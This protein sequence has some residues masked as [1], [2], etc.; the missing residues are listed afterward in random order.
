MSTEKRIFGGNPPENVLKKL[1]LLQQSGSVAPL[2]SINPN[3]DDYLGGRTP[4][5]R[6]WT[7]TQ[8]T[9]SG[10][11]E[12]K[13][14]FHSV[15]EN[16]GFNYEE[17]L[18]PIVS[19]QYQR[20]NISNQ[21]LK[22]TAGITS[23]SSKSEG[24]LGALRST[25]VE[26]EVH[27]KRDFEEIFLPFFLRPGAMVC[28]DFGWSSDR[29]KLYDP[30]QMIS[31]GTIT[32][33]KFDTDIKEKVAD[34]L[35]ELEV[36]VGVVRKY[37]ASI[38]ELGSFKCSLE[39]VSRN[40]SLLDA[41]ITEDNSLKFIFAN[42]LEDIIVK[43]ITGDEDILKKYQSLEQNP[44][45]PT[46]Y[47]EA[48]KAFFDTLEQPSDL[49]VLR[50]VDIKR[51]IFYQDILD[52]GRFRRGGAISSPSFGAEENEAG[53]E[54]E[55]LYICYGLFEDLFLNNFVK[56]VITKKDGETVSS[57]EEKLT[58]GFD[59][60]KSRIKWSSDLYKIQ[61]QPLSKGE[62]L[63]SFLLPNSDGWEESY[64][65]NPN[66][67]FEEDVANGVIPLRELFIKTSLL[68]EGFRKKQNVNDALE[69]IWETIN[70]ESQNIWKIKMSSSKKE[71][72][73]ID[74]EKQLIDVGSQIGFYDINEPLPEEIKFTFDVTSGNGFVK[75]F[76]LKFQTPKAGM[77]SM[78]AISNSGFDNLLFD[79][80][81]LKELNLLKVLGPEFEGKE[82]FL[83]SL[84]DMGDANVDLDV[85]NTINIDFE[86]LKPLSTST[87][88][89]ENINSALAEYNKEVQRIK[90]G[91]AKDSNDEVPPLPM[92]LEPNEDERGKEIITVDSPKEY[93]TA[94]AKRNNMFKQ[95]DGSIS[96]I[97]PIE[98]SVSAYGNNLLQIGDVINV[99]YLPKNYKD[100]IY[101]QIMGVDHKVD[102]SA[103]GV[104][105]N[106]IMRVKP[107]KI[108]KVQMKKEDIVVKLSLDYSRELQSNLSKKFRHGIVNTVKLD[109][110]AGFDILLNTFN[111]TEKNKNKLEDKVLNNSFDLPDTVDEVAFHYAVQNNILSKEIEGVVI[112]RSKRR[113]IGINSSGKD[114]IVFYKDAYRWVGSFV[115]TKFSSNRSL[116]DRFFPYLAD[117]IKLDKVSPS[118]KVGKSIKEV[119][120]KILANPLYDISFS[121]SGKEKEQYY[122]F[123]PNKSIFRSEK[124][125]T[126]YI[127][128]RILND[129]K[130]FLESIFNDY[131]RIFSSIN[132]GI[133]ILYTEEYSQPVI[134]GPFK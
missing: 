109:E 128:K 25:N 103:W 97:L 99:N 126:I 114:Y 117:K 65:G 133:D 14:V 52:K 47:G 59:S 26:F 9:P 29:F 98:L 5:A 13:V 34:N 105:Y 63:S 76:D 56:S 102:T 92:P 64:N 6:M 57:K 116:R 90:A 54:E 89:E 36:V 17:P 41:E 31:D 18:T 118:Y 27:N 120:G 87:F 132:E 32:M 28:V 85:Y 82:A 77:A 2:D 111:G 60:S 80:G 39:M 72:L 37:D 113:N 73:T 1:S 108:G 30:E 50:D 93:Y 40:Y 7:A 74:G 24:A 46:N 69:H 68:S 91:I 48:T 16:R 79:E 84:P 66:P 101:F 115:E 4:F 131:E 83:K 42:M 20:Q 125:P 49:G 62:K 8:I 38:T 10:S 96:P 81:T 75:N 3:Y 11:K 53:E 35:G 67:T 55:S 86:S 19:S 130:G 21:F 45:A 12:S 122:T 134:R 95:A 124:I 15:N 110:H 112:E 43:V 119:D 71:G 106:T 58:F 22:P 23:I 100:K 121:L 129:Y 78:L 123:A 107:N 104:T 127:P 44:F 88:S 61:T 94:L 33:E 51:G 70:S